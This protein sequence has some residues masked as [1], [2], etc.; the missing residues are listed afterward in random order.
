MKSIYVRFII[1]ILFSI[2]TM[3]VINNYPNLFN[4]MIGTIGVMIAC[5]IDVILS[6]ICMASVILKYKK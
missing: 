5:L 6:G 4:S 1:A 2:G 3:H